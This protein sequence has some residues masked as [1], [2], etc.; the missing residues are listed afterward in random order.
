[1]TTRTRSPAHPAVPALEA[2]RTFLEAHALLTD[3]L[4]RELREGCGIPLTWYDV[5]V[6]LGDAPEGR[7]RMQDLASALLFSRSG[8]TR[9]VDRMQTEG[10]VARAGDPHDRRGT[11]AVLT[12][13]GRRALRRASVIHLRGVERHF[14]SHLDS[15][16]AATLTAALGRVR[17]AI[18]SPSEGASR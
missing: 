4:E 5:L 7:L 8:L 18:G 11:Y 15:A 17:D 14:A 6:Q 3:T 16:E 9:L 13:A 2:W 12:E 1:M 10:L